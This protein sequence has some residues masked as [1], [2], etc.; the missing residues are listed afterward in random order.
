MADHFRKWSAGPRLASDA[1]ARQG[2]VLKLAID[3]LG[4]T[5]A[6]AYLNNADPL[7]DG[8]PLDLAIAS[9]EGLQLVADALVRK[10]QADSGSEI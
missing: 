10:Q 7:L 9:D 4:A 6:M 1:A 3:A 5:G 8:R 2:K